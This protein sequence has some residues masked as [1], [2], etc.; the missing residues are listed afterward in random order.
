M[1]TC[2]RFCTCTCI[3]AAKFLKGA[4]CHNDCGR[5]KVPKK[6]IVSEGLVLIHF[7]TILI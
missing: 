6:G 4:L 1:C 7:F 5:I 3:K 2:T